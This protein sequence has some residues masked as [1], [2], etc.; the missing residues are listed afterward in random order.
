MDH[1]I[2]VSTKLSSHAILKYYY[3]LIRVL[4]IALLFLRII[5]TIAFVFSSFK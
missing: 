1:N 5:T 4:N 2:I 3:L